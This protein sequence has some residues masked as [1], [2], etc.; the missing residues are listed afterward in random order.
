MRDR[1]K[2]RINE[3]IRRVVSTAI[4]TEVKDP[5]V[6][7]VT[8]TRAEISDDLHSAKVYCSVMGTDTTK[9]TCVNA[10]NHMN[11]FLQ[12]DLGPALNTRYTPVLEF[13]LDDSTEKAFYLTE[14]IKAARSGDPDHHG[15]GAGKGE[16]TGGQGASE[17]GGDGTGTRGDA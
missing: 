15:G 11:G 14:L 4:I 6:G 17:S 1:R 2:D 8:I 5:R 10:L 13:L 9:K 16:E 7:F 12:K 3:L